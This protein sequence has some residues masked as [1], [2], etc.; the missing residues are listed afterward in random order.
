MNL[1]ARQVM[2]ARLL[3]RAEYNRAFKKAKTSI[4]RLMDAGKR[5]V[6]NEV[7]IK[8]CRT[9]RGLHDE[10]AGI[11]FFVRPDERRKL[12]NLKDALRRLRY[13]TDVDKFEREDKQYERLQLVR[14]RMQDLEEPF[15]YLMRIYN[16]LLD[17]QSIQEKF[18]HGPFTIFNSYGYREEEYEDVMRVLDKAADLV[19]RAG[20]GRILY[21]DVEFTTG[22][23]AAGS[24]HNRND[25]IK[26]NVLSDYRYSNV[27]TLVHEFGHRY[28]YK[29]TTPA[30]RDAYEDD[31]GGKA[32]YLTLKQREDIWRA[33]QYAKFSP[34]KTKLYLDETRLF[35]EVLAR[36]KEIM[37]RQGW[38]TKDVRRNPDEFQWMYKRF[39]VPNRKLDRPYGEVQDVS[40]TDY[41]NTDVLED[42]AEIFAHVVTGKSVAPD[43]MARFRKALA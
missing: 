30:A 8:L 41:G 3:S 6:A 19:K 12:K 13:L 2:I 28:W 9:L 27:Y 10:L 20:F 11:R 25:R 17:Y 37:T 39:V 7:Y 36:W 40:V 14:L 42:F 26:L 38:R 34:G 24:Y 5:D 4:D 35:P 31:F 22:I 15:N 43:A 16:R 21:G 32:G 23:S 29:F 18:K 33:L 1:S